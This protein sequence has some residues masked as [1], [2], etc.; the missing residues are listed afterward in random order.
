MP[1]DMFTYYFPAHNIQLIEAAWV[2]I[3]RLLDKENI[4]VVYINN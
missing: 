2:S 1:I 4:C 3:T